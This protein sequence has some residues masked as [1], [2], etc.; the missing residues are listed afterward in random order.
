MEH[1]ELPTDPLVAMVPVSTRDAAA[2]DTPGNQVSAM[3]VALGTDIAD[4]TERLAAIHDIT[5]VA[6]EQVN[7][8]GAREL[9]ELS[10][11]NPGQLISQ[12]ARQAS[13]MGHANHNAPP[14]NTV[15]TNI[16]GPPEALFM[17]GAR[18]VTQYG[19]GMIHDAMGIMHAI[20][21]YAGD[22]TIS[23]TS[24]RDMMR[25]PAF[26]GDCI[27]ASYDEY[28]AA[29]GSVPS[30]KSSAASGRRQ[31]TLPEPPEASV[32]N[33]LSGPERSE[34]AKQKGTPA[35]KKTAANTKTAARTV[36]R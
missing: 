28:A 16:P 24:D 8:V 14:Y 12:A 25:D 19:V 23:I 1:G 32:S 34:A 20:V 3:Y 5:A 4:P 21:S 22:V 31:S 18:M 9:A 36:K 2:P 6:K 10:Q 17:C 30:R 26:Y 11:L 35:R 7:A 15:V 27:K 33:F 29:A 13:E